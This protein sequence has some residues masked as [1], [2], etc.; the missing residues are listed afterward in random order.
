MNYT[1]CSSCNYEPLD[2]KNFDKNPTNLGIDYDYIKYVD[3]NGVYTNPIFQQKN[4]NPCVIKKGVTGYNEN[5]YSD[6]ISRDFG[7]VCL[8]PELNNGIGYTSYDPRL[9][10]VM[11]GGERMILDRPP[12]N[13]SVKLDKV[14]NQ[15]LKNYGRNYKNYKDVNGGQIMYYNDKSIEDAYYSPNF[16]DPVQIVGYAYRDPMSTI[17]PQY[18]RLPLNQ[19]PNPVTYSGCNYNGC[20][21]S[22]ISDSQEFRQDLMSKQMSKMNQQRYIPRWENNTINNN[23]Q[24]PYSC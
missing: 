18:I 1:S 19:Q 10:D 9:K 3:D 8:T 6:N 22:F 21:L 17:K 5:I 12:I 13:H 24:N 2:N 4:L 14:Y 15:N 20:G 23:T 7:S 16:V 11:R